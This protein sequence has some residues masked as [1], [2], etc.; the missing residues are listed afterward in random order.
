M[1][2]NSVDVNYALNTNVCCR[3]SLSKN[4]NNGEKRRKKHL[5]NADTRQLANTSMTKTDKQ[6]SMI[7]SAIISQEISI[8]F[9][10]FILA[11]SLDL[12]DPNVLKLYDQIIVFKNDPNQ[13]ELPLPTTLNS[14]ER[15]NAHLIAEK[16]GLAH[17]SEGFGH[18]RQL[19]I[20]KKGAAAARVRYLHLF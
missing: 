10:L 1:D 8:C 3:N 7:V 11:D 18:D 17:Y 19:H 6:S 4:E 15:R 20:A 5:Q 12:N 9:D 14:K 13:T 16:L 2:L